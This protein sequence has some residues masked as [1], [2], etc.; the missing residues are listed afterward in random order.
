MLEFGAIFA[1]TGLIRTL[2]R[3]T[4]M[5]RERQGVQGPLPHWVTM[6][7]FL[8]SGIAFAVGILNTVS[9]SLGP[10]MLPTFDAVSYHV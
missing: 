8:P 7:R 10:R 1:V 6:A 4:T 5:K 3:N 9:D 2:A